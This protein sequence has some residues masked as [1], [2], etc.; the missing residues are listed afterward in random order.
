MPT[1]AVI[2]GT[3]AQ[4]GSVVNQLLKA[5]T[6][7][8]RALTRNANNDTAKALTTKVCHLPPDYPI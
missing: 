5:G 7:K 6:W 1:I 3:G 2:G 8:I 4:G